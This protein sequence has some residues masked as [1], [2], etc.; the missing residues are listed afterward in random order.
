MLQE[1]FLFVGE[2]GLRVRMWVDC[3]SEGV[4]MGFARNLQ[5][6]PNKASG[7]GTFL[8]TRYRI[9]VLDMGGHF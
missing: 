9:G 4:K 1:P 8:C 2:T 5:A 3:T 6:K 7:Y